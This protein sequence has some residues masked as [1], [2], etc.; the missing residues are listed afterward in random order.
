MAT[1]MAAMGMATI[2]ALP[3]E[4]LHAIFRS[5]DI[6][7]L[8]SLCATCRTLRQFI[9]DNH[10]L[11]KDLYLQRLVIHMFYG[12][13]ISAHKYQDEPPQVKKGGDLYWEQE[14]HKLVKLERIL[15]YQTVGQKASKIR[16]RL[17]LNIAQENRQ[18]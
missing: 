6:T 9:S 16:R 13:L 11:F 12:Y 14:L 15:G 10:M 5:V 8:A 17:S 4:I 7:D 1:Y 3:H 2:T 18:S